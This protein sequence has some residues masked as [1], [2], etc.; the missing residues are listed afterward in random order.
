MPEDE[1]DA[2][3]LGMPPP[4]VVYLGPLIL[5]LLLNRKLPVPFL[6]RRL[7]RILGLPLIG[8]G[9]LLGGWTFRTMRRADTPIIGEPLVS[10]RPTLSLITDGPFRY[11]RNPGYLAGAM[12][13]TG[14][15]SVTNVLWVFLLMPVTLLMMQ[16]TAIE[17]EERYLEGKFGEE[18]LRY[19]AQVRRWI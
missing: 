18:Y 3:G 13:Y 14:I 2:M 7:T 8:G 9:V 17:R 16:H 11:T 15:A 5:G 4:P 19:K 10:G 12:V 6:P 1:P